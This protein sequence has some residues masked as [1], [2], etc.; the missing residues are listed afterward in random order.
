MTT[1]HT[2]DVHIDPRH[3]NSTYVQMVLDLCMKSAKAI[4]ADKATWKPADGSAK[5]AL[6][7]VQHMVEVNHSIATYVRDNQPMSDT[8]KEAL[9]ARMTTYE[10]ALNELTSSSEG[11]AQAYQSVSDD[12]I[13]DALQNLPDP[14][15]LARTMGVGI[16]HLTY[17][18]GQL[19]YLQTLWN[20]QEDHFLK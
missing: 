16:I 11:L 19:C 14:N 9:K 8:A 3:L 18:W 1:A 10:A 2:H 4:P 7:I 5:S 12:R 15:S 13:K 6:D 20:D 17:H